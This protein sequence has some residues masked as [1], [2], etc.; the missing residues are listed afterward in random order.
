MLPNN[1]IFIDR[2]VIIAIAFCC[3]KEDVNLA[4]TNDGKSSQE[5]QASIIRGQLSY[6]YEDEDSC[7]D[8]EER[9][10]IVRQQATLEAQLKKLSSH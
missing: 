1:L 10:G 9:R 8:R 7:Q 3:L 4:S 2:R 6:L 5:I